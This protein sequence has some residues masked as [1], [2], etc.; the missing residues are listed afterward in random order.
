MACKLVIVAW[1]IAYGATMKPR[2]P[3][4]TAA[5]WRRCSAHAGIEV[6]DQVPLPG[7]IGI[8]LLLQNNLLE[9]VQVFKWEI[10]NGL[11]QKCP[12]KVTRRGGFGGSVYVVLS[13]VGTYCGQGREGKKNPKE[14]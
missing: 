1:L 7:Y 3:C 13:E 14:S 5:A 8:P 12:L 11:M 10:H 9:N 4:G 6:V 2:A